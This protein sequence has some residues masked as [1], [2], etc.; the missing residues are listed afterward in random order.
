MKLLK[1]TI[2]IYG[3]YEKTGI[4]GYRYNEENL[5]H[6]GIE[7][8][9]QY[10]SRKYGVPKSLQVIHQEK[11]EEDGSIYCQDIL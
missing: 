3:C 6:D 4:Y 10:D 5:L 9:G 2:R 7:W 11:R 8:H 1:D